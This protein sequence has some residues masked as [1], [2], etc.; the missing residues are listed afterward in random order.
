MKISAKGQY[1]V[2]VMVEIAKSNELVSIASIAKSQGI[3]PKYLEQVV[4][5]LVK[6]GLLESERGVRGGYK[7]TKSA[8][9][10]SIKSI[11]DTTGDSCSLAPCQ[12]GDCER[13]DCCNAMSVWTTLGGLIN[14]YLENVFLSDLTKNHRNL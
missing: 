12:H 9:Q 4:S 2:R 10:I 13:K 3:S 11:L 1:A 14:N 8:N 7:L 6:N 5:S